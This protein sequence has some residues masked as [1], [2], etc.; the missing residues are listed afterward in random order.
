MVWLTCAPLLLLIIEWF[1]FY[2]VLFPCFSCC[3]MF[4]LASSVIIHNVY[5]VSLPSLDTISF[6]WSQ[7][8]HNVAMKFLRSSRNSSSF[9]RLNTLRKFRIQ[10]L[11]GVSITVETLIP[12][13]DIHIIWVNSQFLKRWI[14]SSISLLQNLQDW[15]MLIFLLARLDAVGI[16]FW[17]LF[18][19]ENVSIL[20]KCQNSKLISIIVFLDRRFCG[21]C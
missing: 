7:I 3:Q 10:Y 11:S 16:A 5:W 9:F 12:I 4:L 20:G 2:F 15:S 21:T 14:S 1:G 8:L 6:L 13:V 19:R 18:S 17:L